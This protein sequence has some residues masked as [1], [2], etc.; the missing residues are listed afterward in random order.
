MTAAAPSV[1]DFDLHGLVRTRV[2]DGRQRDLSMVSRQ[3]GLAP[4]PPA[5][6][7][8]LVVRFVDQIPARAVTYV[9]VHQTGFDEA[10]FLVLKGAHGAPQRTRIAFD[11]IGRCPEIVCE[12][13][14]SAVPHLLAAI[15]LVALSKGV[16]PLHASAF[17][18]DGMGVLVTGWAKSGKT[19]ALLG[20]TRRGGAYVGDEWVYL[21]PDGTMFGLAEPI[22]LWAWHLEQLADVRRSRGVPERARVAGW[23]AVASVARAAGGSRARSAVVRKAL[24][25]LERQAYVRVPP[26][27]L[28]GPEGVEP[29]ARLDAVILLMSS[30][31]DETTVEQAAP[32]EVSAR[33]K[34]SLDDE[35]APFL[36]DY[37]QFRYAFPDRPCDL[38]EQAGATEARLLAELFDHRAAGKVTHP[39]PCDIASLGDAV[40]SCARGVAQPDGPLEAVR[41]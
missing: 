25:V 20:V 38:V 15:N 32:G 10:G 9:G 13:G 16:L 23:N 18:V 8:D 26:S 22:R 31:S 40:I 41:R 39:Y 28:F 21:C 36:A 12:R 6:S 24:P 14:L 2:V 4:L 35:R 17:T 7:P 5:A 37:R 1:H 11:R 30:S 19:E 3:L 33:M 29:E 27:E 34:A